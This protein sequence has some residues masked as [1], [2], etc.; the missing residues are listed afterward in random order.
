MSAS[1][2]EKM[3]NAKD[4]TA[5]A[6][7]IGSVKVTQ[8]DDRKRLREIKKIYIHPEYR[9]AWRVNDIALVL[10]VELPQEYRYYS[11]SPCIMGKGDLELAIRVFRKGRV[12]I[13]M[14]NETSLRVETKVNKVA[15]Q[16]CTDGKY[17]CS[18]LLRVNE[19][20]FNLRGAPVYVRYGIRE[21]DWGLAAL[22]TG[23]MRLTK[24]GRSI[25]RKHLPLYAYV[26]WFEHVIEQEA[27]WLVTVH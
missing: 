17:M 7:T 20:D 11:M 22:N 5:Y 6:A 16:L 23:K 10:M 8:T 4:I 24:S 26:N 12:T 19:E 18:R 9:K 14:S 3:I 15:A 2:L 27:R 13:S 21:S 25:V 1:C